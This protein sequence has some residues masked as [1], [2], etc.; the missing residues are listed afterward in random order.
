MSLKI[1]SPS[2]YS[3]HGY[4]LLKEAEMHAAVATLFYEMGMII[5]VVMLR[6]LQHEVSTIFQDPLLKNQIRDIRQFGQIVWRI[7]IDEIILNMTCL[8]KLKHISS[9]QM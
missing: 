8:D 7:R 1:D 5:K 9:N 4:S 6:M 3:M 2:P